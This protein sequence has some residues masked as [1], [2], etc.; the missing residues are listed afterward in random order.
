L[1]SKAYYANPKI[2]ES[3]LL[4][5]KA[6][7]KLYWTIIRP[8]ITCASKTWVLKESVKQKLIIT[9]RKFRSIV[10]HTEDRGGTW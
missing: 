9:E 6:K 1:G 7:V 4:S 10:R 8:L 3:K 2:F 5:K